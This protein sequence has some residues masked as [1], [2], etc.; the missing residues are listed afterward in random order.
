MLVSGE[1]N[2][3]LQKIGKN[4]KQGSHGLFFLELQVDK[5][6]ITKPL[7]WYTVWGAPQLCQNWLNWTPYFYKPAKIDQ[8]PPFRVECF[9]MVNIG[10]CQW[11]SKCS[12]IPGENINLRESTQPT[13][14]KPTIVNQSTPHDLQATPRICLS[15][16]LRF[17]LFFAM[18][19]LWLPSLAGK[20]NRSWG[21]ISKAGKKPWV[22]FGG[23]AR[24]ILF[25]AVW[26]NI[27]VSRYE[28]TFI[29]KHH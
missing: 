9:W 28:C 22:R 8:P 6:E 2:F 13:W 18:L 24:N 14:G 19:F 7:G 29:F 11:F 1:G 21:Q 27:S 4:G 17:V 23:I 10:D 26:E 16:P 15:P 20:Q 25:F 5:L 3:T 12:G